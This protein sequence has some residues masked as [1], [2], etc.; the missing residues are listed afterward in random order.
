MISFRLVRPVLTRS[1]PFGPTSAPHRRVGAC[2]GSQSRHQD[3][4]AVPHSAWMGKR[5]EA[6][7][8]FAHAPDCV[9]NGAARADVG[10]IPA[11][12]SI[13]AREGSE[14]RDW[15]MVRRSTRRQ[16]VRTPPPTSSLSSRRSS[17]FKS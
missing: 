1:G 7:L 9:R 16:P 8:L 5:S 10:V 4:L 12:T 15:L 2:L 13:R 6:F 17:G 3:R 14:E 11:S